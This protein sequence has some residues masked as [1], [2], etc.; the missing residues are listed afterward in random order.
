M[1]KKII[2]IILVLIVSLSI[3]KLYQ[4]YAISSSVAE[5]NDDYIVSLNG[6]TSVTVPA[7]SSKTV[8]YK[9]RNTNNGTV[10]YGVGYKSTNIIVKVYFDSESSGMGLI[11]KEE[12][13]F[14]KLYLENTS[15]ASETIDLITILGYEN[16]GD[17][18]VPSGYNLVTMVLPPSNFTKYITWLYESNIKAETLT[19]DNIKYNFAKSVN[20]M[21]DRLG[22]SSVGLN[23]GNIRYYGANPNNY[24]YFNCSDYSNQS[25]STCEVWRIIGVFG[26]KVK[27]MRNESIGTYSWDNKTTSTGAENNNGKNDWTTARLMKL[28]N[29]SDYYVVDSN[30]NGNGQSLYWNAKGGTCFSGQSNA[31]TSCDFTSI[32]LKNDIT[33]SLISEETFF[34]RGFDEITIYQSKAYTIERETGTVYNNTRPLTWKGKIA[35]VY[36]SDYGYAADITECGAYLSAYGSCASYNW[37]SNIFINNTSN[38]GWLLTPSSGHSYYA[39]FISDTARINYDFGAYPSYGVVPTLYL[40]SDVKLDLTTDGSANNPYKLI[41]S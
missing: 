4:T 39:V 21:N 38:R 2:I 5:D 23:D 41:I 31:T 28:L 27:I 17:L 32:G 15:S 12:N 19:N 3:T 30:D 10:R 11:S 35:L 7:G 36:P 24:I 26:G 9:I 13:K 37:M 25:S 1:K 40:S 14:I 22:S 6:N 34:I 29:P 20:L 18:I 33:R 16:G 8:Y